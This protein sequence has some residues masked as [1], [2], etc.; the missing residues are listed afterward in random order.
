MAQVS[1]LGHC[2]LASCKSQ[3]ILQYHDLH[4]STVL[5]DFLDNFLISMFCCDIF[6][7]QL[8]FAAQTD[9]MEGS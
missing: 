2:Y 8:W 7:V 9:K 4:V 1:L 5:W 3:S 6:S